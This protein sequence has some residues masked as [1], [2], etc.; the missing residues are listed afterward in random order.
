MS[1]EKDARR[2]C[3]RCGKLHAPN[4]CPVDRER[5]SAQFQREMRSFSLFRAEWETRNG[6]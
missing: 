1:A 6:Y 2:V 3:S 4:R 5:E